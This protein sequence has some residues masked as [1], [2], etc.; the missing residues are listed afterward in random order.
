M[1]TE[2]KLVENIQAEPP[3]ARSVLTVDGTVSRHRRADSCGKLVKRQNMN[4]KKQ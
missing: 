3:A 2:G 1:V 4:V